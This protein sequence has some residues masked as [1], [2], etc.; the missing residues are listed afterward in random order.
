MRALHLD[1]QAGPRRAKT[2]AMVLAAG[3]ALV[4]AALANFHHWRE[5]A[6]QWQAELALAQ[7]KVNR[8]RTAADPMRRRKAA[9][10]RAEEIKAAND[11]IRQLNFPWAAMFGALEAATNQDVAL[12]GIEPDARKNLVRV[13]AECKTD[14]AMLNYIRRLQQTELLA[15]VTLQKHEIQAQD[16]ERPLRFTV[17]GTLRNRE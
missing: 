10:E 17:T 16:A 5:Q 14:S 8:S 4:I 11:V 1:Y 15:D 7:E 2:A 12:L 6:F 13:T 3:L 9:L